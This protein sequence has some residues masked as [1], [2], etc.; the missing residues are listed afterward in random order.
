MN[1]ENQARMLPKPN[2]NYEY[3]QTDQQKIDENKFKNIEEE[4]KFKRDQEKKKNIDI[5]SYTNGKILE[6]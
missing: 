3:Q 4:S 2:I 5:D 1:S 6:F